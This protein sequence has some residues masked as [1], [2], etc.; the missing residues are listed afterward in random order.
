MLLGEDALVVL[1]SLVDGRISGATADNTL[2]VAIQ[3]AG[4]KTD[5][6]KSREKRFHVYS[7]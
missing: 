6:T 7:F 5:A 4:T 2:I 1:A 3:I